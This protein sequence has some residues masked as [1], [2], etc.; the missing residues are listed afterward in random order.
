[1]AAIKSLK[2]CVHC[3]R[4]V[5]RLA[6][7]GL[8]PAC[9]Y[10]EKRNG[11][12][13]YRKV[14]KP[15]TIEGCDGLSV[16]GG[17]CDMHYRRKKRHG[18]VE[19]ERFDKWG[20]IESHPLKHTFRWFSRRKDGLVPEWRDF[21]TF[22][23]GVGE[24]PGPGYK[25]KRPRPNEPL[26]PSNMQWVPPALEATMEQLAGAAGYMRA[27]RAANPDRF[28]DYDLKKVRGIGLGEY[29]NLLFEQGG[30]CAICRKPETAINPKTGLP[31][32]LAVDH[33]H[34]GGHIRALLC[35]ACNTGLGS[36]GDDPDRLRAAI[37]YLERH[38]PSS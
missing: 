2:T 19:A 26:G 31:R 12:L 6:A 3:E 29:Q 23:A 37:S 30:T 18:V 27:Y 8:C 4:L 16:S 22:V 1:M 11:T 5:Y 15:C 32:T 24:R 35:S 38:K 21:W 13:D 36:F 34:N 25:L 28:K 33:C 9:Y 7:R 17:L 20:H 10:R 14:R